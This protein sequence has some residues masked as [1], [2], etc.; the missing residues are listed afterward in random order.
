MVS[1]LY[2]YIYIS[3]KKAMSV[4]VDSMLYDFMI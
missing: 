1:A 2:I 3:T 4:D